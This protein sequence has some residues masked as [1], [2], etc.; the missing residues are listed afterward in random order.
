MKSMPHFSVVESPPITEM[1]SAAKWVWTCEF[2]VNARFL[3]QPVTGVQCYAREIF[4]A[5]D[6]VESID[7]PAPHYGSQKRRVSSRIRF[8]YRFSRR[9][10]E[11]A[12]DRRSMLEVSGEGRPCWPLRAI[13]RLG[14]RDSK[15]SDLLPCSDRKSDSV[16]SNAS[17]NFLGASRRGL[18]SMLCG[19]SE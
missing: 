8:D 19:R 13:R 5:M 11:V 10:P 2:V 18:I 7:W 15:R 12:S 1:T 6:A 9:R 3:S 17:S 14:R 16:V 4:A